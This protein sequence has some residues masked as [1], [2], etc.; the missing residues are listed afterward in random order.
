VKVQGDPDHPFTKGGLCV[1]VND[2]VDRS[3]VRSRPSPMRR[4]GAQGQRKFEP[5]TWD[6]ALDEIADRFK[7]IIAEHGSKPIMPC[8]YLGTEGIL[9][10]STL[11]IRSSIKLARPPP[12]GPTAI[13]AL[14]PLFNDYGPSPGVDPRASFTRAHR[15]LGLQHDLDQPA[16]VA[17]H[18]GGQKRGAKVVVIDPYCTG[19]RAMPIVHSHPQAP[20]GAGRWR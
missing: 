5:V 16:H 14:V 12:S 11:E 15:D 8:S 19:L 13:R 9:N 3:T 10:A 2:Y 7:A 1:K 4:V 17:L 18:S 6:D 20:M